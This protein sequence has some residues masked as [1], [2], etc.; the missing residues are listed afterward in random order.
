[1]NNIIFLKKVDSYDDILNTTKYKIPI[2]F[3]KMIFYIKNI[4]NII[5]K[6]NIEGYNVWILPI[7]DR[8]SNKKIDNIVKKI[9]LHTDNIYVISNNLKNKE[10][11]KKINYYNINYLKKDKIKIYLIEKILDYIN[12]IQDKDIK[13]LEITILVNEASE[14]NMYLIYKLAREVRTLK[15]VTPNIYKFKKPEE[16]LYSEDGIAIQLSNSYKRSLLKSKI[17]I[18]LDFST[19]NIN[20]YNVFNN[21]IIINCYNEDIKIKSKLFNG[22]IINSCNIKFK[23]E[24]KDRFIKV[25]I[26]NQYN[27]LDIYQSIIYNEKDYDKIFKELDDNK[28]VISDLIGNN[29]I[30]D[31]KEIKNIIKKLDK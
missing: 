8:Y 28:V 18:N 13:D 19:I 27:I 3:K 11:Y 22:L 20:E 29:G 6:K 5:T 1:M 7:K 25:G 31:K 15:I 9:S 14:L 2:F 21:A 4:F 26:Y 10:F 16:K 30:I 17:I 24:I 12:K 23:K